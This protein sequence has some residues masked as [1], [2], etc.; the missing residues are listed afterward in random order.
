MIVCA[1]LGNDSRGEVLSCW[2]KVHVEEVGKSACA[3]RLSA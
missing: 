3:A 2:R 1:I